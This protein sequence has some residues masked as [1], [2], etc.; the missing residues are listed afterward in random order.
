M[1]KQAERWGAELYPEDVE[2][3]SV[4]TAPFTVQSSERKVIIFLFY[5]TLFFD[6]ECIE[7]VGFD[8]LYNCVFNPWR[9]VLSF[10]CAIVFWF[11]SS[12]PR[13]VETIVDSVGD[14]LLL[15]NICASI[16]LMNISSVF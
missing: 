15:L 7:N 8:M 6:S 9:K 14:S 13:K 4:K 1:R 3:L 2:S 5:A 16:G 11:V 12:S 10:F